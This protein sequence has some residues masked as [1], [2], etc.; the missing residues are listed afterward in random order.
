MDNAAELGA[1]VA[2]LFADETTATEIGKRG[3]AVVQQNK[4]ALDRLLKL[5]EPLLSNVR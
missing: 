4:G 1:A 3:L 2:D 5:L